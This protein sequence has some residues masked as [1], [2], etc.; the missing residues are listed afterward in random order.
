VPKFRHF[1]KN[2]LEKEY[3]VAST[4]FFGKKTAKKKD[5]FSIIRQK[6]PELPLQREKVL[7]IFLY[8]YFEYLQ[9]WLNILCMIAT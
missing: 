2:I 1:A 6:S 4:I 7:N 8:L 5:F 3:S 9:I